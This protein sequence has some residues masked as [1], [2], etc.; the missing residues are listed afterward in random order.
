MGTNTQETMYRSNPS[1]EGAIPLEKSDLRGLGGIT[2][3]IVP[4]NFLISTKQ[5]QAT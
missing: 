3:R 1:S 4:K 2:T 5:N